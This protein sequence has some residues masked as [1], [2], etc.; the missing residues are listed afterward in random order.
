M[1]VSTAFSA[2]GAMAIAMEICTG[3]AESVDL[4][5]PDDHSD[6]AVSLAKVGD[7]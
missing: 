3:M 6:S 7:V 1:I 2:H 5:K 4:A